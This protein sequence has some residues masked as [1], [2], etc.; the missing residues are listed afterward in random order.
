MAGRDFQ[1]VR[2][3]SGGNTFEILTKLGAVAKFQ[4][5]KLGFNSVLFADE[6]F[7]DYAK[8]K[9]ANE[10]E[11]RA[12]FETNNVET[13][14]RQIIEK[15]ELQL[16]AADRKEK[17]DK[18]RAEMVNYIHKYYVHPRT[19][20]PHPV[21]RIENAFDE[22]RINV[23]PDMPAERQLQERVLRRL[24]EVL[25]ITKCEIEGILTIPHQYLGSAMGLVHKYCS[26]TGENY[27]SDG[28]VMNIAFVP[29]DYDALMNDLRDLTKGEFT[30][31]S[32]GGAAATSEDDAAEGAGKG[33][34]KAG[35]GG[36]GK[37]GG[38]GAGAGAGRGHRGAGRK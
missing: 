27:T 35:R 23:D 7:T 17:V 5:G 6:I 2:F 25:P 3:K 12:A 33:K 15:G 19:R 36:K 18:K 38:A 34:G 11:L 26:V 14:A 21:L 20:T 13:C 30:F 24:P 16:T 1:I 37:R 4:D 32:V 22:L 29:G 28:S 10:A 9:R 31:N 8:G